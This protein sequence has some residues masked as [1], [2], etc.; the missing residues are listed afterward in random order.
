MSLGELMERFASLPG[1][2]VGHGPE[3]PIAP[4]RAL[5]AEVSAFLVAHP[6]LLQDQGYVDFLQ[7]YAGASIERHEDVGVFILGFD[8][9]SA[10][11]LV[12]E[13]GAPADANGFLTFCMAVAN[14]P[15]TGTWGHS[16]AFDITGA[17]RCGIYRSIPDSYRRFQAHGHQ[18]LYQWDSED[19]LQWLSSL[20]DHD[21]V[22]F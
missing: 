9:A 14:V 22:Y 5:G 1:A 2:S 6:L 3:H 15:T 20:I 12:A 17:R 13:D 11:H 18:L 4:N 21:G 19:F 16:F 8:T 10:V 7:Q